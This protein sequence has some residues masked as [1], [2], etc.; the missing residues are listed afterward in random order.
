MGRLITDFDANREFIEKFISEK[1]FSCDHNYWHHKNMECDAEKPVFFVDD[2][3]NGL[4]ALYYKKENDYELLSDVF[5]ADSSKKGVI[6]DFAEKVFGDGALKF[7]VISSPEL[8]KSMLSDKKFSVSRVLR[9]FESPVFDLESFDFSLSGGG[10]KKVRNHIN[11]LTKNHRV[12]AVDC[13]SVEK[14]ALLAVVDEWAGS[15]SSIT[16]KSWKNYFRNFVINSFEGCDVTRCVVVDGIPCSVSAGWRIP[17][18]SGYYSSIGIH[19]YKFDGLGEFAYIDELK[20]L[21]SKGFKFIDLGHSE[22]SFFDFKKKFN[23]VRFYN[24]VF[25]WI[26]RK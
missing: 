11:H 7:F 22:K 9:N 23:P 18:S 2:D 12:D 13:R 3:N 10:W 26:G 25:Y 14:S 8:R 1:G 15:R 5:A 21:K 19:N 6:Y 24:S 16:S 4:F 17:N 20:E